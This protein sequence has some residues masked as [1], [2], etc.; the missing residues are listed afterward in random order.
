MLK[1][2]RSLYS[3]IVTVLGSVA[4]IVLGLWMVIAPETFGDADSS[5][6]RSG[7]ARAFKWVIQTVG[8]R[9]AGALLIVLA[10][11]AL[12]MTLREL[13]EKRELSSGARRYDER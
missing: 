12:V 1:R 2:A 4:F 8:L 7:S 5:D 10:V 3:T 9:P 13:T 6:P 11:I